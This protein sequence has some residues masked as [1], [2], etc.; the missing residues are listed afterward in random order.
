MSL[1]LASLQ[2]VDAN[3]PELGMGR[4]ADGLFTMR[5]DKRGEEGDIERTMP[6][7]HRQE[8]IDVEIYL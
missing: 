4:T 7:Q 8:R 3:W 6:G 1:L 5:R 2:K